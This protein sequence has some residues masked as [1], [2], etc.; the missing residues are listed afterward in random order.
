[1]G[2]ADWQVHIGVVGIGLASEN[3]LVLAAVVLFYLSYYPFSVRAEE[4]KLIER[5]GP[6]YLDYKAT[7]PAIVPDLSLYRAPRQYDVNMAQWLRNIGDSMWF[8]GIFLFMHGI[9]A[10]Q[11][12]G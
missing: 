2:R 4:Q 7:V 10:L 6:A 5:F 1:V 12:W 3:L 11:N 8:V 9:E